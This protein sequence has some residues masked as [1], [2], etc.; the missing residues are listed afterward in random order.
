[1][2][3]STAAISRALPED[4]MVTKNMLIIKLIAPFALFRLN[5]AYTPRDKVIDEETIKGHIYGMY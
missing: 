1:M 3:K 4:Q 5:N 2:S